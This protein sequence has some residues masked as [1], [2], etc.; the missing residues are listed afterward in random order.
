MRTEFY[1]PS[2]ENLGNEVWF[3]SNYSILEANATTIPFVARQ[4]V[5]DFGRYYVPNPKE[6]EAVLDRAFDLFRG[7]RIEDFFHGGRFI[8]PGA[9]GQG[10]RAYI[11]RDPDT[12]NLYV[13][14]NRFGTELI[15]K[16]YWYDVE[17]DLDTELDEMS[18]LHYIEPSDLG[19]FLVP[20]LKDPRTLNG[21]VHRARELMLSNIVEGLE[22][23]G[24]T[25]E[26]RDD[27][28]VCRRDEDRATLEIV[29]KTTQ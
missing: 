12:D 26:P 15:E 21:L 16:D 7:L 14:C 29:L 2:F 23:Q 19:V 1:L 18:R 17:R 3:S 20:D 25:C 9:K 6:K 11:Y 27:Y 5:I 4:V 22:D 28:Y 10:C 13:V 8:R 24:F